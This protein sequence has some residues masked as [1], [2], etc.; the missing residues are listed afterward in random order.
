[1]PISL[2]KDP[3]GAWENLQ[4]HLKK[5]VKS[6]FGTN[7]KSFEEERQRLL[8]TSGVLFQEPFLE[9]LPAYVAGKKLEELDTQDL[10]VISQDVIDAFCKVA[11]A[12]LIPADVNMYKH[13]EEMLKKYG[14]K[15]KQ[16]PC[17]KKL[18]KENFQKVIGSFRAEEIKHNTK[19][20]E[21]DDIAYKFYVIL[22]GSV[23]IY[24][25][26]KCH[27]RIRQMHAIDEVSN[28]EKPF[29]G[30]SS[31]LPGNHLRTL[32]KN[33]NIA[34]HLIIGHAL[35]WSYQD[36]SQRMIQNTKCVQ[37]HVRSCPVADRYVMAMISR[38]RYA[39]P[40]SLVQY[41]PYDHDALLKEQL[42]RHIS[43]K[44]HLDA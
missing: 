41:A 19:I 43:H 11:G 3:I 17:F 21:V 42:Q 18:S 33:R 32:P 39:Q 1:M 25:P 36:Q 34:R 31:L 8:D 22:E 35:M 10:P 26:S 37:Y 7:S 13:Q 30:E 14:K 4:G 40:G 2:D 24:I 28:A 5:Y 12:S 20:C 44:S 9:V 16:I 6:A 15:L 38:T 29:F 27:D 23:D